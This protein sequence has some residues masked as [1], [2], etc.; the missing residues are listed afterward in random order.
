MNLEIEVKFLGVDF[1]TLREELK[2]NNSSMLYRYFEENIVFDTEDKKLKKNNMLLRLRRGMTNV[3]CLKKR[4]QKLNESRDFKIREEY[5]VEVD[6]FKVARDIFINLGFYES[7]KYEK[8]REV[9]SLDDCFIFLDEL[10]FGRF[11]EIEGGKESISH[12]AQKL[13]LIQYPSTNKT[14]YQLYLEDPSKDKALVFPRSFKEKIG[15]RR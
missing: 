1:D 13:K 4:P 5:E 9:W 11:V 3:L 12:V 8:I 6:D 15:C 10:P 14:Y 2:R 7:F